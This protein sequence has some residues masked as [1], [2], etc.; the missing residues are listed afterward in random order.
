[1]IVSVV[2]MTCS[3]SLVVLVMESEES[4]FRRGGFLFP[5]LDLGFSKESCL[6]TSPSLSGEGVNA[7]APS[8]ELSLSSV[9]VGGS[10]WAGDKGLL[11]DLL[12]PSHDL[13]CC[14]SFLVPVFFSFPNPTRTDAGTD[15][16][17][18]TEARLFP[19]ALLPVGDIGRQSS[20][21]CMMS[22]VLWVGSADARP[23]Y[24]GVC[25][26]THKYRRSSYCC[27][28]NV[29]CKQECTTE[30]SPILLGAPF[31]V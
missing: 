3:P 7:T 8:P 22:T 10:A 2:P 30:V 6:L 15:S 5:G 9:L 4:C 29:N 11:F 12:E 16:L 24:T 19:R 17:P 28:G 20:C 27:A 26:C 23:D 18:G 31:Y 14:N 13:L 25:T 1:M 21:A